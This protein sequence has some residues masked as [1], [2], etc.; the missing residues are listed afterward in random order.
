MRY[1]IVHETIYNYNQSVLLEPHILRLRSRSNSHQL[2]QSFALEI[3]PEPT[4]SCH[5]LDLEGNDIVKIWY[6]EPTDRLKITA[7]SLVETYCTNPFNYLLE[8][9]ATTLPIDYPASLLSQLHPYLYPSGTTTPIDPIV[10]QLAREICHKVEG[11]TVSF[12]SELNQ[13]IYESCQQ[14]IRETGAPLLPGITWNQK[15]G[16]CRDFAVLFMEACRVVGLAARFVSGYQE[17]D[18]DTRERHLHAWVEVY[19]PGAGWRGF[20]PTQGLAVADRNISLAASAIPNNAAPVSG[21]FRGVGVRS[22]MKTELLI[23]RLEEEVD[24]K[25]TLW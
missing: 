19:L 20:D 14:E 10:Y 23:E 3:Y 5:N 9:W 25:D 6:R 4:G 7:K 13:R 18:K 15:I 17:G 8:P 16:S 12:L 2:L 24:L 21:G 11:N 1:H 22:Q